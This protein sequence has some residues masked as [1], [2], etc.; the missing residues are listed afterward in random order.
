MC[1]QQIKILVAPATSENHKA[2]EGSWCDGVSCS[3]WERGRITVAV[4]PVCGPA[5]TRC[6]LENTCHTPRATWGHPPPPC[7]GPAC[8]RELGSGPGTRWKPGPPAPE[9]CW[10]HPTRTAGPA[11]VETRGAHCPRI[12]FALS[13][14]G[15]VPRLRLGFRPQG[16]GHTSN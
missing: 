1:K 16:Q 3:L 15:L 13:K 6:C 8:G 7:G 4:S 10:H 11:R 14:S 12:L 9:P 2:N 5:E